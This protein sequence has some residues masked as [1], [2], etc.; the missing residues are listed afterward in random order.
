M[1][2]VQ[3]TKVQS[4]VFISMIFASPKAITA[5]NFLIKQSQKTIPQLHSL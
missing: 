4:F 3:K 1:K 5:K 2:K